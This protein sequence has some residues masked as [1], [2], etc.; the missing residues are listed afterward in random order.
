MGGQWGREREG[1]I[2]LLCCCLRARCAGVGY[3]SCAEGGGQRGGGKYL[4]AGEM[5]FLLVSAGEE[6]HSI[7]GS[8]SPCLQAQFTVGEVQCRVQRGKRF[9]WAPNSGVCHGQRGRGESN[10]VG[11]FEWGVLCSCQQGGGSL[12]VHQGGRQDGIG[13]KYLL[14]LSGQSEY[15]A[16]KNEHERVVERL[17]MY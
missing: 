11:A 4:N 5:C 10:W 1:G 7:V 8:H 12:Y 15:A 13:G 6:L 17:V 14:L 2:Y 3:A 9:D 16:E